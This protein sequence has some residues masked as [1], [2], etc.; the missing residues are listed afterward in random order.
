MIR[1]L[2]KSDAPRVLQ[3][4]TTHFPEEERLLGTRP[5]GFATV[6]RRVFRWDTQLAIRIARRLGRPVFRFFVVEED[7]QIVA[8]TLLSFPERSGYVSMVAVDPAYRR[9][10]HA[11]ELL[12]LARATTRAT[13][14]KFIALD[15]LAGNTPARTLYEGLG[16]RP[17]RET[18]FVVREPGAPP[19][20]APSPA[21]RPFRRADAGPLLEISRRAVPPEVE[22]VLPVRASALRPSSMG[23]RML[24]SERVAWVIDRGAGAEAYLSA[25]WT[26]ATDAGHF[27]EPIV[28][29]GLPPADTAALVRTAIDWCVSHGSPRI[30]A[31]V[32]V[33]NVRGHAALEGGGFRDA[34]AIWTL[35]RSAV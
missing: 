19:T 20:G 21:V 29:E 1:E 5:E 8:T 26:P 28:G 22:E 6:V 30:V 18:A 16:Y 17:L 27:S 25:T 13:G 10:G 34:F 15:V 32:P 31:Q 35:Y 2:R 9:R 12:E 4:L 11:R 23:D 33:A 3:F 7:G 14:R 24:A